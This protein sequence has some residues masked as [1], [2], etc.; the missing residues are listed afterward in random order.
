LRYS[1]FQRQA[2]NLAGCPQASDWLDPVMVQ[3]HAQEHAE[4]GETLATPILTYDRH[5]T[6]LVWAVPTQLSDGR[7]SRLYVIGTFVYR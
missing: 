2:G 6:R 3:R 5:P 1:T 4:P 7:S